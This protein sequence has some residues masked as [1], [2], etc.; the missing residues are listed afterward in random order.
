[1]LF[2]HTTFIGIDPTAGKRPFVYTALDQNL[3][4]MALGQGA[5]DEVLAFVAGQ[6]EAIVAVCAPRWTNQGLMDNSEVRDRLVPQPRPGRWNNFRVAEYQLRMRNIHIPQTSARE[7]DCPNWMQTGY[8]LFRRLDELGYQEYPT[9]GAQHQ[10]IEVYPHASY[11]CMLERKPFS[12]YSLE[13]RLQRQLILYEHN[14]NVPDS[15]RFFEEITRHRLLN[16]ILPEEDLYSPGELDALVASYTA[17]MVVN[18]PEN[19]SMVGDPQ[20]GQI[21]LPVPELKEHY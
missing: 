6:R 11:V 18:Q 16:G 21:T 14:I 19:T 13:G 9:E 15:M 2:S 8:K 12:K 17:W 4:V 1:M 5:L 10:S 3:A 7:A 20:E